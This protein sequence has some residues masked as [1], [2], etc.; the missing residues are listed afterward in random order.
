[1]YYFFDPAWRSHEFLHTCTITTRYGQLDVRNSHN[2]VISQLSCEPLRRLASQYV[3]TLPSCL[4]GFGG[5]N[6]DSFSRE[7]VREE[8]LSHRLIILFV[9]VKVFAFNHR[10]SIFCEF[11]IILFNLDALETRF[12]IKYLK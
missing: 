5:D 6:C 11:N 9:V 1:M 2:F 3:R 8:N 7:K 12:D 10:L 4:V